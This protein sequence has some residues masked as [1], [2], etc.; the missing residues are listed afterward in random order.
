QKIDMHFA[1]HTHHATIGLSIGQPECTI[2][3]CGID[4]ITTPQPIVLEHWPVASEIEYDALTT[5]AN[6][7]GYGSIEHNG[8]FYGQKAHALRPIVELPKRTQEKFILALAIHENET[9]DLEALRGNG[10]QLL[11]P[12]EVASTPQKFQRFVQG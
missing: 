10:W 11:D 6:W 8:L 2:P 12:N 3:T 7:R 1:G 5:V 9:R 4:W